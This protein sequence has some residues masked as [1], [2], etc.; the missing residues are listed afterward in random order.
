VNVEIPR[1][2][3]GRYKLP[4]PITGKETAFTRM[5]TAAG[6]LE[7][8]YGLM[9]HK[10]RQVALGLSLRPDL[11]LLAQSCEPSDK[12][13]LDDIVK[14]A[15][16]AAA[17]AFKANLGTALHAFTAK[18]D[19]GEVP[20]VPNEHLVRITRYKTTV[21]Q[22]HLVFPRE[23]IETVVVLPELGLCGTMDRGAEW[24]HS[25]NGLVVLDVKTGS[26]DY[27]KVKIA[28][29]LAGYSRCSHYLGR[30]L[31]TWHPMPA[32]NQDVALVLW[33]PAETD[34]EP[35]LYSVN[36]DEGWRML[37][38]S[39]DVRKLRSGK[40]KHLFTE[41]TADAIPTQA[42]D[43]EEMLRDRV[44]SLVQIPPAK[45]A[46]LARWPADMPTLQEGGLTT[47][48]LDQIEAWCEELETEHGL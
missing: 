15:E 42:A 47:A 40:G 39:M 20:R 19:M 25:K 16:H 24:P 26:L 9:N 43:R 32:Y 44:R 29:Q 36:I 11:V 28:Q 4:D 21:A 46:L 1:D 23:F 27:A 34:D 13:V 37:N 45:Q 35:K 10:S 41:I 3:W 38:M 48:Q 12:K 14:Q 7:D 31:K 18:V 6:T 22:H 17:S 8:T 33:L 5:T 30:D 2:H